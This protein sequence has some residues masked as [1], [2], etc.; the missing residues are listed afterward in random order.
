MQNN[1]MSRTD[2]YTEK[3]ICFSVRGAKTIKL[4][5]AL[6]MIHQRK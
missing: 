1:I 5:F 2:W 3:I 6:D 4:L